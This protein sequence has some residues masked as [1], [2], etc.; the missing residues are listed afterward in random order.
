M[1][2]DRMIIMVNDI[3]GNDDLC[4]GCRNNKSYKTSCAECRKAVAN[5]IIKMLKERK[6]KK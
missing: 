6:N 4:D 2:I 3:L 5:E 1:D